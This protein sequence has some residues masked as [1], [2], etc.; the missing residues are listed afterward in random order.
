MQTST[1]RGERDEMPAPIALPVQPPG[2][3]QLEESNAPAGNLPEE[4]SL[5]ASPSSSAAEPEEPHYQLPRRERRPSRRMTYDQL[6]T[7][8]CYSV[9][10]NAQ[11]LPAYQAP[12][13]VSWL[14]PLQP[15]HFQPFFM[16]G[17]Q[18]C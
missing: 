2:G 13:L 14:Q 8:S 16:Y 5:P 15:N 6:G 18:Q 12:G 1:S 9:Q 3:E 11:M 10:P 17:L 4:D 7:P